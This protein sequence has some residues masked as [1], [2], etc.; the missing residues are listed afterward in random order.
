[1]SIRA[2]HMNCGY[3]E[4]TI[5]YFYGEL[6]GGSAEMEAHLGACASCAADLA[7][8]K[9]LSDGFSA[10][11]PEPPVLRASGLIEAARGAPIS[12]QVM[13]WF[14]SLALSGAATAVFLL[15]FQALSP[16]NG[17][18]AWAEL[19][20]RLDSVEYNIYSL[21]DDMAYSSAADFDYGYADIENQKGEE[22]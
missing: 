4:K 10:F 3:K 1:M 12:E 6:P 17:T 9:G 15:A 20:S 7:A 14:R 19:D 16:R 11:R 22:I 5:L 13:A 2:T 18:S 21:Q 8:L